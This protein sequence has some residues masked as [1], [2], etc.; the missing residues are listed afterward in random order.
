MAAERIVIAEANLL[1]GNRVILID[2]GNHAQLEQALDRVARMQ[3]RLALASSRARHE[4]LSHRH[5]KAREGIGVLANEPHLAYRGRRL[6]RGHVIGTVPCM[7]S[8]SRPRAMEPG[9]HDDGLDVLV[10]HEI[11]ALG[12][13][14]PH[15]DGASTFPSLTRVDEPIL[16]TTRLIV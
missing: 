9:R 16:I 11:G 6:Q 8:T 14:V 10:V 12:G 3:V 5:A 13:E 2:D 4:D 1:D 7:P 15:E